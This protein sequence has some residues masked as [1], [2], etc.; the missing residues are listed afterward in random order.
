MRIKTENT[1]RLLRITAETL[2]GDSRARDAGAAAEI[3]DG[4]RA[5]RDA[6]CLDDVLDEKKVQGTVVHRKRGALAGAIEGFVIGQGGFAPLDI[7][8]RQRPQRARHLAEPQV[9]EVPF[10]EFV[11]E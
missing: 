3:D 9:G 6:D 2:Q 4:T 11:Q 10:F 5:E 8:R 7:R 1:E